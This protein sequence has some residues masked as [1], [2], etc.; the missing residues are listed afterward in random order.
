ML[1]LS[2]SKLQI[3]KLG[4]LIG[5]ALLVNTGTAQGYLIR[6]DF[7][8]QCHV[9]H[10]HGRRF[11]HVGNV[12]LKSRYLFRW[13]HHSWAS[14]KC[15]FINLLH[16]IKLEMYLYNTVSLSEARGA[17][18]KVRKALPL[19]FK[20]TEMIVKFSGLCVVILRRFHMP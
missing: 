14:D 8:R 19:I 5:S 12:I 11:L 3:L 15:K 10:I 2:A 1:F 13:Y 4:F 6:P 17:Y 18:V 7:F 20:E 9:A 16:I